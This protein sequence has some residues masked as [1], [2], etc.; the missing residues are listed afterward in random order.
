MTLKKT[1][2]FKIHPDNSTN[3]CILLVKILFNKKNPLVGFC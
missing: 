3:N 1:K 2:D